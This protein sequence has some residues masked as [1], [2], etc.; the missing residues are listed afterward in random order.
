[1]SKTAFLFPG[2]GVQYAGMGKS[3][4]EKEAAARAV[5]DEAGRAAGLDVAALCFE[6]N[7][8]LDRTR[9][10]QIALLTTEIAIL[11][12][13]EQNQVRADVTAGMSLGEYGAIVAAG[14]MSQE[15]AFRVVGQ[16]GIIM[17][18]ASP[19]GGA[20]AAVTGLPE[21]VVEKICGETEWK[22]SVAGYNAPGQTVIT[23]TASAVQKAAEALKE[24]GAAKVV[25][26]NVSGP[27]HSPLLSAAGERLEKVLD[28][29]SV[30]TPRI[31]YVCSMMGDYVTTPAEVKFLL[32]MQVSSPV[33][34][35]Q[36]MERMLA[37]GVDT[38]IEIGPGKTLSALAR[39]IDKKARTFSVDGYEDLQACL[40]GLKNK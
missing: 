12:V 1:M 8:K 28:G 30:N 31:P 3:F 23:G 2:Q 26:L 34:W 38:F 20:M 39:R 27:F 24:A 9:Y 32:K 36:S 11:R 16:R 17:Q 15:D 10:T 13:L 21:D 22:V 7:D 29:V 37:D 33:R 14:V 40:E 35:R 4:Y 6:K 19:A 5:Y 18:E 25:P